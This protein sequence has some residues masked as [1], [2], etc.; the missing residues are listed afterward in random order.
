MTGGSPPICSAAE[1]IVVELK[2]DFSVEGEEHLAKVHPRDQVNLFLFY[3]EC[4]INSCRHS[5]ATELSTRLV[6]RARSLELSVT[7]NGSGPD[8]GDDGRDQE[9][10]LSLTR[11]AKFLGARVTRTRPPGG[12]S[13]ITLNMRTW[14]HWLRRR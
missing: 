13:C 7:D 12:G 2:H 6:I 3:K 1:R 11:R 9:V 14:N 4:L 10:P 8:D 5:G